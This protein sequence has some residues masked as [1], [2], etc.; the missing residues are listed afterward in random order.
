MARYRHPTTVG[1]AAADWPAPIRTRW[2]VAIAEGDHLLD[3]G[4]ASH[5]S[6]KTRRTAERALGQF[7][8]FAIETGWIRD[9]DLVPDC[10]GEAAL[11]AYLKCLQSRVGLVTMQ[12]LL[13]QLSS[14]MRALYPEFDRTLLKSLLARLNF[15]TP[16]PQKEVQLLPSPGAL[17][18]LGM[19]LMDHWRDRNAHDLRI[20][21][22]D[23]RNGLMIA[24]LALCPI[25][26]ANLAQM[27]IGKH[28]D[29]AGRPVRVSFDASETKA[30]RPISFDWPAELD[31]RLRYYLEEVRPILVSNER[32]LDA[33]WPSLFNR[34]MNE[35]GIYTAITKATKTRLGYPVTPHMF[36]DAAATY[37]SEM[38]PERA[39]LA[40]GVL[41]HKSFET[42]RAHYV[43]G[44]QH[45][46]A[47]RY[48][49]TVDAIIRQ[50][51]EDIT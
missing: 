44:Q 3:G 20:N 9:G 17:V 32:V 25:R 42:T 49:D 26:L 16:P 35:S 24:L 11:R 45:N 7:V 50:A 34:P 38:R 27:R 4:H 6:P 22:A 10:M 37:V 19:A 41:Q 14:A 31:G 8:R 40:A 2:L 15:R 47:K 36:R 13:R 23:Y 5:W 48:H 21:A 43:R 33:M 39:H 46:A 29:V 51:G 1:L 12:T 18:E 30:K 28:V